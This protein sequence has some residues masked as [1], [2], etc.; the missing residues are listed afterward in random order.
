MTWSNE[1]KTLAVGQDDIVSYFSKF[2][3]NKKLL[4]VQ[5]SLR[6]CETVICTSSLYKLDVDNEEAVNITKKKEE[7]KN[8]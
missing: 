3:W 8:S 6:R 5:E 1:A 7:K 2:P 4:L